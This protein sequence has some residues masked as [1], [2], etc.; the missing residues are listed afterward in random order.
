[1]TAPDHNLG[2]SPHP[3]VLNLIIFSKPLCHVYA[4]LHAQWLQL[5]LTLSNS[6]DHRPPG[7]S[8]HG[9]LHTRI[10]EWLP[11]PPPGDLP[12]LVIELAGD[13]PYPVIELASLLSLELAGK[14]FTISATWEAPLPCKET[15]SQT[16]GM[17][18]WTFFLTIT[19]P[20]TRS[21]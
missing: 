8:V 21:E 10:L 13:L 4:C 18:T 17:R 1:M 2:Q 7:S 20:N 16:L 3:K 14:F 9:I 5:C 6:M 19:L 15:Y 11:C 12:Y